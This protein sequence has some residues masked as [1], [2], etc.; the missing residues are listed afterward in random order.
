MQ[1]SSQELKLQ[2]NIWN[3][4]TELLETKIFSIRTKMS[5]TRTVTIFIQILT[6][7]LN[8]QVNIWTITTEQL[9]GL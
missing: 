1:V 8:L 5:V 3:A 2:V 7:E 4:M 6:Q 9:S